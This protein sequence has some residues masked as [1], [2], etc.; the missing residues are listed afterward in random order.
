MTGR[1]PTH[2]H[3]DCQLML[4]ESG[5]DVQETK[6]MKKNKTLLC[7]PL[8]NSPMI[9]ILLTPGDLSS[10]IGLVWPL[11]LEL[12]LSALSP[13]TAGSCSPAAPTRVVWVV[14][15]PVLWRRNLQG[16]VITVDSESR[17][18]YWYNLLK[19][20]YVNYESK[21]GYRLSREIFVLVLSD[22][23]SGQ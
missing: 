15:L 7:H 19:M 3:L 22:C 16:I 21:M 18:V 4:E 20:R 14:L 9:S 10:R 1:E 17:Q 12:E 8:K 13:G 5:A 11:D 2:R 6:K 23:C